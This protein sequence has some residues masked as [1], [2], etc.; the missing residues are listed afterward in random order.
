MTK[1]ENNSDT[2]TPIESEVLNFIIYDDEK[3]FLQK[4]KKIIEDN[5]N[6]KQEVRKLK[7]KIEDIEK[8]ITYALLK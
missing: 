5:I 7:N 2:I 4:N 6:L 3:Q 8:D 1:N